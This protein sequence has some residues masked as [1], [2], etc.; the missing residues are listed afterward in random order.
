[1]RLK[2]AAY[3]FNICQGLN[4]KVL[5][6]GIARAVIIRFYQGYLDIPGFYIRDTG[7]EFR[8][9]S[10]SAFVLF[11]MSKIGS[12]IQRLFFLS[13]LSKCCVKNVYSCVCTLLY[14]SLINA[15]RDRFSHDLTLSL[16]IYYP[17][18]LTMSLEILRLITIVRQWNAIYLYCRSVEML[19]L[20]LG[21]KTPS[22]DLK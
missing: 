6:I 21:I 22:L 1:M 17:H 5:D 12:I 16:E 3:L 14:C 13:R 18:D 19:G 10:Y 4:V 20:R 7:D 15:F 11:Q 8:Q 2:L 9:K